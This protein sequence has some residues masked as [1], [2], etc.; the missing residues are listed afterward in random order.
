MKYIKRFNQISEGYE[1]RMFQDESK[2]GEEID[3]YFSDEFGNEFKVN[4]EFKDESLAIMSYKVYDNDLEDWAYINVQTNIYKVFETTLKD[5][6]PDFLSKNKWCEV[7][8][9]V[10]LSKPTEKDNNILTQRTK[11]YIRYLTN[12]PIEG[13][14]ITNNGNVIH[15]KKIKS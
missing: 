11:A 4:F 2:K 8:E 9:M 12:N 3:Y 1:Y 6:L 13:W 7:V 15:F 5:I 14:Y 10:G